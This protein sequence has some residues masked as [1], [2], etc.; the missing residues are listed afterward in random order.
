MQKTAQLWF[1][2]SYSHRFPAVMSIGEADLLKL[3]LLFPW[4]PRAL[5][6]LPELTK[7]SCLSHLASV[8]HWFVWQRRSRC[9]CQRC[10]AHLY[11]N[12]QLSPTPAARGGA[13]TVQLGLPHPREKAWMSVVGLRMYRSCWLITRTRKWEYGCVEW[14]TQVHPIC[15]LQLFVLILC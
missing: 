9:T 5:L 12:K 3:P 15:P 13:G 2:L 6:L 1:L 10:G 14:C 7:T 4:T 11:S 8:W